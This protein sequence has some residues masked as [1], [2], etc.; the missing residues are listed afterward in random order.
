MSAPPLAA[1]PSNVLQPPPLATQ[2]PAAVGVAM[3]PMVPPPTHATQYVGAAPAQLPV[4]PQ[5]A[6]FPPAHH[7]W[8]FQHPGGMWYPFSKIDSRTLE[9]AFAKL[10][11]SPDAASEVATDGG[12]Y[13]V[14]V[15]ARTRA[16]VFW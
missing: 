14:D 1:P 3:P 8:F 10:G 7:L 11:A 4:A 15:K 2:P 12:R 16:P 13:T 5:A 9:E 6:N